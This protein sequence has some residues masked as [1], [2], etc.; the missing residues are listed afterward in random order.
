VQETGHACALRTPFPLCQVV[1]GSARLCQAVPGCDQANC[2]L[3]W[4]RRK[5][6][7]PRV[8][9]DRLVPRV[10]LSRDVGRIPTSIGPPP[11]PA[12]DERTRCADRGGM[13]EAR[14][15]LRAGHT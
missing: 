14:M 6:A 11:S 5:T 9:R 8:P 15:T 1:P 10:R 7:P 2:T 12:I 3:D 13:V 4:K